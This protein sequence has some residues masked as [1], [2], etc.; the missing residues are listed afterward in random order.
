MRQWTGEPMEVPMPGGGTVTLVAVVRVTGR[1]AERMER[2]R[3][4]PPDWRKA[5]REGR[6]MAFKTLEEVA[7]AQE[8]A[9]SGE[10]REVVRKAWEAGEDPYVLMRRVGLTPQE[11]GELLEGARGPAAAPHEG[12]VGEEA[13]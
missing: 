3:A 4:G 11:Q 12:A 5:A 8:K 9:W 2:G 7:R 13:G 10:T 1:E 6:E